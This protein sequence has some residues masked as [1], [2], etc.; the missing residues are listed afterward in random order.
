MKS[1]LFASFL[2]V[3]VLQG[4]G[5]TA[6]PRL[7]PATLTARFGHS[8]AYDEAHHQLFLFGGTGSEGGSASTDQ[9][10]LWAWDGTTWTRIASAGPSP[11][12]NA[13]LVYDAARQR[14]V[15]Y[16][17]RAGA[18]PN[19]TIL[20]DTWEWDGSTWRRAATT[21]PSPRVHQQAAFDRSRNLVIL[22]GGFDV[23]TNQELRDIWEW[24]GVS[25][26]RISPSTSADRAVGVAYDEQASRLLLFSDAGG[27]IVVDEW[28]GQSL[29]RL[30][31]SPPACIGQPVSIGAAGLVSTEYCEA[32]GSMQTFVRNGSTWATV[33]A[34][35]PTGPR[36]N[37]T[38]AYDRGR[39]RVVLFGGEG[40]VQGTVFSDTWEWDGASW[41]RR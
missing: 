11:R 31:E 13:S 39:N 35:Q 21:A 38:M 34:N 37:Y 1:R 4:C 15:L 26:G 5:G 32:T 41:T 10:S 24:N 16:G 12:H 6:E 2:A 36:I 3:L 8:T 30:S 9:S 20:T 40:L 25:W 33:T 29:T 27:Q 19:E 7:H 17:G 14:V 23:Q 22:Y 18:F 28:N